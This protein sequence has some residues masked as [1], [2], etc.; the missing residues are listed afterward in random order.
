M[1]LDICEL[2]SLESTGVEELAVGWQDWG[3]PP[4]RDWVEG[5]TIVPEIDG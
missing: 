2:V 3:F 1:A 5:G 4:E